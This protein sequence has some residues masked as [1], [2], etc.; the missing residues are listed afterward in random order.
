MDDVQIYQIEVRG[1]MDEQDINNLSPIQMQLERVE[2]QLAFASTRLTV[3]TD[4]S[5]LI[6]LLRHLHGRGVFLLSVHCER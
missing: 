6:G 5:G 1:P 2:I 4:Q 3:C